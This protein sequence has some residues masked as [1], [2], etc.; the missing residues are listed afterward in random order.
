MKSASPID[1]D[2]V[3]N[4]KDI[5]DLYYRHTAYDIMMILGSNPRNVSLILEK[6]SHYLYPHT[7][8]VEI[9]EDI[10]NKLQKGHVLQEQVQRRI[11]FTLD[12]KLPAEIVILIER[13]YKRTKST[14]VEF[15][16]QYESFNKC[17]F[18]DP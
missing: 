2:T 3:V 7:N 9:L 15:K 5:E 14:L 17:E 18:C 1:Y 16:K 11:F 6:C 8:L 10:S 13:E 12:V 4:V